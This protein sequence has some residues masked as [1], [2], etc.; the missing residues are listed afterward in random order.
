[1]RSTLATR[2]LGG[3]RV[4]A[5]STAAFSSLL[6]HARSLSTSPTPT[7]HVP[8]LADWATVDPEG[9]GWQAYNLGKRV[10]RMRDEGAED[11]HVLF[12]LLRLA[13]A[14]VSQTCA[15]QNAPPP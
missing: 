7:H 4:G 12:V 11:K 3:V 1:M 10:E 2:W 9:G 5:V 15:P 14:L 8:A 6:S 13:R